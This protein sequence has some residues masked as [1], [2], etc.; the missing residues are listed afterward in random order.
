MN[1]NRKKSNEI[2]A[3]KGQKKQS[4]QELSPNEIKKKPKAPSGQTSNSNKNS[5][6]ISSFVIGT[7]TK[8]NDDD[9]MIA[10][11]DI[12]KR[13]DFLDLHHYKK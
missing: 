9:V 3:T 12:P 11:E 7:V 1:F 13:I 6:F 2:K 8:S 4:P 5:E 10:G